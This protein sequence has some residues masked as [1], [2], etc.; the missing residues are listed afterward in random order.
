MPVQ[1]SVMPGLVT[2][3][4]VYPTC[5]TYDAQ[6][7]RARVAVHPRLCR[8]IKSK[9]WMAGTSPAMTTIRGSIRAEHL[10]IEE[11]FFRWIARHKAGHDGLEN[12]TASTAPG[13]FATRLAWGTPQ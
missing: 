10:L 11:P 5:G 4:R 7:G 13:F 12:T 2:A 8:M 9:T 6:L 3:S 1:V